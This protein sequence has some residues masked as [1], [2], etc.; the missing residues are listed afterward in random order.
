MAEIAN[1]QLRDLGTGAHKVM[2]LVNAS[3]ACSLTPLESAFCKH[4]TICWTDPCCQE[5]QRAFQVGAQ[6]MCP[7]GSGEAVNECRRDV[8]VA[9]NTE[10]AEMS[11]VSYKFR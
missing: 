5:M 10:V 7:R 11:F 6:P 8:N 2:A 4:S 3:W 1:G 9:Y